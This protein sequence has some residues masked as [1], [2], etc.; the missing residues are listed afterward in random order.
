MGGLMAEGHVFVSYAR[1]DA[2]YVRRL[3]VMLARAGV[4]VWADDGIEPGDEWERVI[5][6]RI[7]GSRAVLV[8]MSP[9]ATT[10]QW[11]AVEIGL[12]R[13]L[14]KRIL[15]LLYEGSIVPGL[16]HLQAEDVRHRGMPSQAFVRRLRGIAPIGRPLLRYLGGFVPEAAHCFQARTVFADLDSTGHD[17]AILPGTHILTGM[18]GMG[19]TQLAAALARR[20]RD[21]AWV[22]VLVWITAQSQYAIIDAYARA[23]AVLT[24]ADAQDATSAATEFLAYLAG[25]TTRWLVVLDD[26]AEP[27]LLDG[28]WPPRTPTGQIIVTTRRRDAALASHGC[29]IPVNPFTQDEARRYLSEKF[30]ELPDRLDEAEQ[31]AADVGYLPLMLGQVTAFIIDQGITCGQYRTLF[32][33][34]IRLVD[35]V[36]EPGSVPDAYRLPVATSLLLSVEA[37]DSLRPVGLAHPLLQLLSLLDPNGIPVPVLT[38]AAALRYTGSRRDPPA[39]GPPIQPIQIQ[40]ACAA[41]TRLNLA[42]TTGDETARRMRVHALVQRAV[43]DQLTPTQFADAVIAAA[44]AL[45][46]AWPAIDRDPDLSQALR[47]NA[48]VLRRHAEDLLWADHAHPLL[49]RAGRSLGEAGLATAACTYFKQLIDQATAR[50]GPDHPDCLAARRNYARWQGEAGDPDAAVATLEALLA[51]ATELAG[52]DHPDTLATRSDLA[53]WR[54]EAGYPAA[55][56]ANDFE[57]LLTEQERVLGTDHP[58]TLTTR[59]NLAF[60][61]RNS[62]AQRTELVVTLEAIVADQTRT[63]GRDHPDTMITRHDL[64]RAYGEAGDPA[65]AIASFE[66]LLADRIRILGPDHPDTMITRGN[67]A[68]FWGAAGNPERAV[69]AFRALLIDRLRILGPDHPYTLFNRHMLAVFTGVSGDRDGAIAALHDLLP[70]QTRVLGPDN[71]DTQ[72]TRRA[73]IYWSHVDENPATVA[74][75][76]KALL[77]GRHPEL[78]PQPSD[79]SP[80]ISCIPRAQSNPRP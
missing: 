30:E 60:W 47:S 56:V 51:N 3:A 46:Q 62:G 43:R 70:D 69:T 4:D 24:G 75:R 17:T 45:A 39:D 44:D 32:A 54:G 28:W 37:A 23:A 65:G 48:T 27:A 6:D 41:L 77:A 59:M 25:T 19:K 49:F 50:L 15:P 31:L 78:H 40:S 20:A 2:D 52:P 73:L 33:E 68:Y 57:V 64:A 1:A 10:S 42:I 53:R 76:F 58:D 72:G 22:D 21:G 34:A 63:L 14:G 36:P 29:L 13:A 74:V 9:A 7:A 16:E 66:A 8:V 79:P 11:V 35:L 61:R 80:R 26:L 12:A 55:F 38:T 67:L 71:P 18:G 5:R